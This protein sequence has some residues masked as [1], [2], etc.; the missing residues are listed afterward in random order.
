MTTVKIEHHAAPLRQQVLH[1]MRDQILNGALR[2]G[3]RLRENVLCEQYGVSRT[4]IREVLRQLESEHLITVL[5][6]RGPI[7]TVLSEEDIESIYQVRRALEGLAGE[8]FALNAN[9]AQAIALLGHIVDMEQTYLHGTVESREV[10]KRR[11]Y[12]LLLAGAGNAVL[13]V[14]LSGIHSRIAIFRRAAF[15]DDDRVQSSMRELRSVV[16]AAAERRDPKAARA[17]CER[18]I[19]LAGE[20]AVVEY[21]GRMAEAME[22]TR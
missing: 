9:D 20:L 7:V 1:A 12:E 14:S 15:L 17:A 10:S 6:N 2:P 5:P 21:S 4:V 13:A 11:F 16:V 18:H 3:Q 8:L 19:Q 22:Q